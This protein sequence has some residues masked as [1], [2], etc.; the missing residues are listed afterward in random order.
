ME[1]LE[2][3]VSHNLNYKAIVNKEV[4]AFSVQVYHW[5]EDDLDSE[6]KPTWE[7]IA[8]PFSVENL[9]AAN[10]LAQTQLADLA[11]EAEDID[12]DDSI[13]AVIASVIG[14]DDFAFLKVDNFS[15]TYLP[16]TESDAF[17]P[18]VAHKV[19]LC[20]EFYYVLSDNDRWWS[21]F[22]FD[23]GQIRCWKYFTNLTE[24]LIATK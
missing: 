4:D 15:F 2:E 3:Y 18:L 1:T 16:S 20:G 14:H 19:L 8:G 24:A 5:N 11:G 21:G 7:R 9:P 23:E 12:V 17:L 13:L 6:G 22:L 10:A